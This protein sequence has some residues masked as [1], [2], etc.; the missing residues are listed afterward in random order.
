MENEFE[1]GS[2]KY[3]LRK[4][5]A[6][7]QFHIVRRM[8]PILGELIPALKGLGK[9]SE[10]ESLPEDQKFDQIATIVT[11]IMNGLSKLSDSDS[12]FV[13]KGLLASVEGQVGGA[14]SPIAKGEMLMRSDLDLPILIQL[15]GRAFMFNLSGFFAVLPR[16]S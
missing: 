4:V 3:K 10:F 12:E 5:D 1:I 7:K 8:A 15:A 9:M 16:V 6:F 2:A 14:W 11:P 13:L